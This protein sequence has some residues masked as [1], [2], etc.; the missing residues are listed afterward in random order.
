MLW[1]SAGSLN[2]LMRWLSTVCAIFQKTEGAMST[3]DERDSSGKKRFRS[4]PNSPE[5]ASPRPRSAGARGVVAS[6]FHSEPS[7]AKRANP[8]KVGA[9]EIQQF[10]FEAETRSKIL[11]GRQKAWSAFTAGAYQGVGKK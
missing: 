10:A 4:P 9:R 6:P 2:V 7:P 8:S 11:S 3:S 1:L 5:V